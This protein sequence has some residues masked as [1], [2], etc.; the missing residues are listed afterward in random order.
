MAPVTKEVDYL[1]VGAGS[2]GTASSR[3]AS[4][5]YGAKAVVVESGPLGGTCVNVG[6]VSSPHTSFQFCRIELTSNT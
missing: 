4:S 1:V 2:A 5:I 3:R 6:L